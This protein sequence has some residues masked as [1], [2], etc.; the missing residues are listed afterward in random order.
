MAKS[1][2]DGLLGVIGDF[3]LGEFLPIL[4]KETKTFDDI[5]NM[6]EEDIMVCFAE[7]LKIERSAPAKKQRAKTKKEEVHNWMSYENFENLKKENPEKLFC[8]FATKAKSEGKEILYSICSNDLSV[9][10]PAVWTENGLVEITQEEELA[11]TKG[12]IDL[13]RCRHCMTRDTGTKTWKRKKGRF[14]NLKKEK[15]DDVVTPISLEGVSGTSLSSYFQGKLPSRLSP[16]N[17]TNKTPV[18]S[19]KKYRGLLNNP[20]DNF[21]HFLASRETHSKEN[22]LLKMLLCYNNGVKTVVGKFTYTPVVKHKFE[23]NYLDDV[24]DLDEGDLT[25]CKR[26][27]VE[28]DPLAK[29]S[30]IAIT[31]SYSDEEENDTS[32]VKLLTDQMFD[33]EDDR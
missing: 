28:Y 33:M 32:T 10:P 3:I 9:V 26:Y 20:E 5:G 12:D 25:V 2:H 31:S 13:I 22:R 15:E 16:S 24:V 6:T 11:D 14:A 30:D 8:C 23:E 1:S 29:E 7:V 4:A 18:L 19:G 21:Y 27:N 17:A